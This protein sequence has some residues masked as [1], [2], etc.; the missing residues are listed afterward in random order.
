MPHVGVSKKSLGSSDS[1]MFSVSGG[2]SDFCSIGDFS[3]D[4]FGFFFASHRMPP[5]GH[6]SLQLKV[7]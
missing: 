6:V 2:F 5:S 7:I 1:S 4:F 3:V